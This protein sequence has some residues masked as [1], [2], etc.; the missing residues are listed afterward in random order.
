MTH[1]Y[2]AKPRTIDG[3]TFPSTAE[4]I[5]YIQLKMLERAGDIKDLSLQPNFEIY[6]A[7]KC[8]GKKYA[9]IKYIADFKYLE[10]STG[11]TVIEDV[12]GKE[13]EGFKLKK[14]MFLSQ[15]GEDHDFRVIKIDPSEYRKYGF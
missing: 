13:T 8:K 1:K 6:K 5:R 11:L 15:Y 4:A 10:R 3:I 2:N 12:K 9:A 14:K 7:F